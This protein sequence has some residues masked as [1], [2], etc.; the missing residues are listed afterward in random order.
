MIERRSELH[1]QP[2]RHIKKR[3][4]ESRNSQHAQRIPRSCNLRCSLPRIRVPQET[5]ETVSAKENH[6]MSK[7]F[8]SGEYR[9]EWKVRGVNVRAKSS[10]GCVGALYASS[11]HPSHRGQTLPASHL[12][13]CCRRARSARDCRKGR[14]SPSSRHSV[15]NRPRELLHRAQGLLPEWPVPLAA[16]PAQNR[17][18]YGQKSVAVFDG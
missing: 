18:Q 9:T 4:T 11:H 7:T 16:I 1:L 10:V 12:P 13:T 8:T 17:P 2:V 6:R 5:A 15:C 3:R 14:D